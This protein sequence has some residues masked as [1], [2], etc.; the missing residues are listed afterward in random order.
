ML[1]GIEF[2]VA[3]IIIF[4]FEFFAII[5]NF[6]I[7]LWNF[8]SMYGALNSILFELVKD[9]EMMT[10]DM[11]LFF[12]NWAFYFYICDAL[13]NWHYLL[14]L[15]FFSISNTFKFR[16]NIVENMKYNDGWVVI[17]SQYMN[18]I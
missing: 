9:V 4:F 5:C 10:S 12:F 17:E 7:L 11:K 3:S 18:Y 14:L 16:G 13:M 1:I 6:Y 15:D 2:F 8:S